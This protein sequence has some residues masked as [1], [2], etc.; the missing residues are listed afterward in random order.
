MTRDESVALLMLD[1][2][3][4]NF[5]VASPVLAALAKRRQGFAVLHEPHTALAKRMPEFADSV[6]T[7]PNSQG[8]L[9]DT[10]A[11]IRLLRAVRARRP[12][13]AMDFGGSGSGGTLGAL[14]G[15]GM[16]ICRDSAPYASRY[17]KTVSKPSGAG[18][19]IRIYGAIARA[20]EPDL[21]WGNPALE[22]LA[23]DL[24]AAEDL[25]HHAGLATRQPLVCLHVAGGK[26]YKHW[27]LEHYGRLIRALH[28]RGVRTA[29][30]GAAPDR[31]AGDQ[32]MALTDH[33][34]MDLIGRMGLGTL[35]GVFAQSALF[36]GN[37]SGPMHT[38][39]ACGT[40]IIALFGPTDPDRWGPL[41]DDVTIVRGSEPMPA[42]EGKKT[43]DD[44][45]RMDSITVDQVLQAALA[46]L[47]TPAK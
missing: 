26:A 3:L 39:A 32:V 1:R 43:F 25:L 4:G 15:A 22:P 9:R 13:V 2:H 19:R 8:R 31:E 38:A 45:R 6:L 17:T 28:D 44:G 20:L 34:P 36:I 37:D 21:Q 16:R 29:L 5:L 33:A 46:R 30:I 7:L 35:I 12:S 24:Q 23:D 10:L 41:T 27:P 18:H 14:S 42:S 47:E 11:F 40:G